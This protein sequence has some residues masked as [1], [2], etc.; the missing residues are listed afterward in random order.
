[1][2]S[3]R[4]DLHSLVELGHQDRDKIRPGEDRGG[5]ERTRHSAG[6]DRRVAVEDNPGHTTVWPRLGMHSYKLDLFF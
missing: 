3:A 6:Q 2:S 4:C 5:Q 1:M